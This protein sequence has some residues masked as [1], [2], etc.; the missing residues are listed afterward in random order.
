MP[1]HE[2]SNFSARVDEIVHAVL[3]FSHSTSCI[4]IQGAKKVNPFK[5]RLT[6][7]Y[8]SNLKALINFTYAHRAY[9][10]N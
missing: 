3:T 9:R 4:S 10:E 7:T 6:I 8:C 1:W 2:I 5:F